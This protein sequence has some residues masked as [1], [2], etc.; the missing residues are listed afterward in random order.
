MGCHENIGIEKF[1]RQGALL[2]RTVRV[3]FNYRRPEVLGR[4]IRDDAEAPFETIFLLADERAVRATE[5]QYS[6]TPVRSEL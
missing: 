5:C 6:P 1:P 4:C 2:G 3:S